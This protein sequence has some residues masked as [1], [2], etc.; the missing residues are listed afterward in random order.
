M[1]AFTSRTPTYDLGHRNCLMDPYWQLRYGLSALRL[2][3]RHHKQCHKIFDRDQLTGD[4]IRS[5]LRQVVLPWGEN[6]LTDYQ[7][8][9][10]ILRLLRKI[11][12]EV[13]S[14]A[15]WKDTLVFPPRGLNF[16]RLVS[17][18]WKTFQDHHDGR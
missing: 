17:S 12:H 18:D 3:N 4:D 1:W 6:E 5:Y 14:D 16:K 13:S 9:K 15:A 10:R 2:V 8:W 7:A 11:W